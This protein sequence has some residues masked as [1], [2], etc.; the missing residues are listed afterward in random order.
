[1][2]NDFDVF[3]NSVKYLDKED[4]LATAYKKHKS[5]DKSTTQYTMEFRMA[6]QKDISGLLY[7]LEE[8]KKLNGMIEVN[9]ALLKPIA[10]NLIRKGQM[11]AEVLKIF[12]E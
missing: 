9:F 4:I 1:M 10:E 5:L 12:G 2:P 8:G 7:F 3:L 11:D 6:L